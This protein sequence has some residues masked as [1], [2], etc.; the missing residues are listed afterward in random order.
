MSDWNLEGLSER[1]VVWLDRFDV[2]L[3][4]A[5]GEL[6][7]DDAGIRRGLE[8]TVQLMLQ[9]LLPRLQRLESECRLSNEGESPHRSATLSLM[10]EI[11][12]IE[13]SLSN[14]GDTNTP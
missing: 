1:E 11:S 12:R 5:E 14:P 8:A 7:M 9:A 4:D 10:S 6:N 3:T 13:G 2:I